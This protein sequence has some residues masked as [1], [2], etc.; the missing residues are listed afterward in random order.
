MKRSLL[1]AALV[2]VAG[3][4]QSSD[5]TTST[6]PQPQ[7]TTTTAPTSTTSSSTTTSTVATTTT[8]D[9]GEIEYPEN[10]DTVDDLPEA[11][12]AHIGSPMPDPD[13]RISGPDDLDRW[14]AGWLDWLAWTNANPSQG[15]EQLEVNMV[16]AS[17]QFE[18]I[19]AALIDRAEAEQ[20]LLGGG[21]LPTGLSGTFDEFFEDKTA[22]RIVM[23]AGGP[24]SYL[25]ND[26]GDVVSVFEGID[27][28][29]SISAILRYEKESDEWLMETFEVLGRS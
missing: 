11:L 24:P 17:Q 16:S 6:A 27:G 14:M 28:E 20:R 29:V 18:D 15:A 1:L 4:T 26:A 10:P 25:V 13:L 8:V 12:T 2:V 9:S 22:L 7:T 5:P 21:F 19:Q 3:C 23:V